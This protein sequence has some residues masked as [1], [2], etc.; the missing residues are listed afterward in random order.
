[1]YIYIYIY[2]HMYVYIYIMI[3]VIKCKYKLSRCYPHCIAMISLSFLIESLR[4]KTPPW[5]FFRMANPIFPY[6]SKAK[7][8]EITIFQ[9]KSQLESAGSLPTLPGTP[10]PW[11]A[12]EHSPAPASP[13]E[14]PPKPSEGPKPPKPLERQREA[15]LDA[16]G[17]PIPGAFGTLYDI[18]IY[19]YGYLMGW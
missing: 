5:W 4:K 12:S 10:V 18:Y 1:M 6:F 17:P 19:I 15:R 13:R 2:I 3:C 14:A 11:P 16:L 9:G 7:I 8:D